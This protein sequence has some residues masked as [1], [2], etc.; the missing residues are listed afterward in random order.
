VNPALLVC[1]T[2]VPVVLTTTYQHFDYLLK[3]MLLPPAFWLVG[4]PQPSL[5][6]VANIPPIESAPLVST[7]AA[8]GV[9]ALVGRAV[10]RCNRLLAQ[11]V[12]QLKQELQQSNPTAALTDNSTRPT[13]Q[14]FDL[15]GTTS[16]LFKRA[17]DF[18]ITDTVS[19]CLWR[20]MISD[21]VTSMLAQNPGVTSGHLGSIG[22]SG[23]TAGVQLPSTL[24]G[25][26]GIAAKKSDQQPSTSVT[27]TAV[28]ALTGGELAEVQDQDAVHSQAAVQCGLAAAEPAGNQQQGS[29]IRDTVGNGAGNGFACACRDPK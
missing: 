25:A 24:G 20:P 5:I 15:H 11:R 10:D 3:L 21:V 2:A 27:S 4:T 7:A 8:L 23:T 14:L 6:L 9:K 28:A 1:T 22:M 19:P 26:V 12:Q 18:G 13:I 16:N 29:G 17:S